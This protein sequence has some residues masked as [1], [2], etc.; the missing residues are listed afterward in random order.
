[1]VL[2]CGR[3]PGSLKMLQSLL[4]ASHPRSPSAGTITG[5]SA[6]SSHMRVIVSG[7]RFAC[8]C[9]QSSSEGSRR[10]YMRH[11]YVELEVLKAARDAPPM[12]LMSRAPA[13]QQPLN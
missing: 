13:Q 4:M 8:A 9:V 3:D 10:L 11:G 2:F 5:R 12:Y 6:A 7:G 1:M